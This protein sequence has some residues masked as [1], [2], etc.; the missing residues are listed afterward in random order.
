MSI[1]KDHVR[2]Y[3]KSI[4]KLENKPED[5]STQNKGYNSY[6]NSNDSAS[7]MMGLNN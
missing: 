7:D 1:I 5:G 2:D 4:G 6:T 3:A